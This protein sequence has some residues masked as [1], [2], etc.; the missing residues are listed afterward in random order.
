MD[1]DKVINMC[2]ERARAHSLSADKYVNWFG[3]PNPKY[4]WHLD[5]RHAYEKLAIN[6][7]DNPSDS[8]HKMALMD[9]CV[10]QSLA[11]DI[12]LE[13]CSDIALLEL[14]KFN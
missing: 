7:I 1:A 2:R 13:H 12:P 3:N 11:M 6:A 5:L 4:G 9:G 14:R 8:L 10:M